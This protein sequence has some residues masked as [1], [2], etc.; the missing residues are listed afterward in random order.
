MYLFGS[1]VTPINY[2]KAIGYFQTAAK[3]NGVLALRYLGY[4]YRHGAGVERDT[5]A[6]FDWYLRAAKAGDRESQYVVG[7]LYETGE[8]TRAD[9]QAALGWYETA[10]GR[11]DQDAENARARLLARPSTREAEPST[12]SAP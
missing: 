1:S 2:Q 5:K 4:M 11:G 12:R 6:G 10:A 3:K 8:G 7:E 9:V